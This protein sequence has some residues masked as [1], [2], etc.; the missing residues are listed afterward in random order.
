VRLATDLMDSSKRG[1]H[2]LV[3]VMGASE[4]RVELRE[5]R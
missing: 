2:P 1:E 4:Q 3:R 5:M